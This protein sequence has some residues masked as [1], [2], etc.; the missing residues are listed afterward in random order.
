MICIN[1]DRRIKVWLSSNLLENSVKPQ[2]L[3]TEQTMV[4]DI[5]NIFR[6]FSKLCDDRPDNM[7]FFQALNYT[8]VNKSK[9]TKK[10]VGLNTQTSVNYAST[11]PINTS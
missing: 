4:N 2:Q 8:R 1:E 5:F 3:I 7:N 6:R 10:L 9:Q 11:K